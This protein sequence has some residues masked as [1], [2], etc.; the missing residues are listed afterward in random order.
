MGLLSCL[1]IAI[2]LTALVGTSVAAEVT[3]LVPPDVLTDYQ[4]WLAGRDPLTIRAFGGPGARRDVVEVVLAQQALALGGEHGPVRFIV[5]PTYER[6]L[7][8]LMAGNAAM[9]ATSAW[10]SDLAALREVAMSHAVIPEGGFTAGIYVMPTNTRALAAHTLADVRGLAFVSDPAWKAD[11]ATLQQLAP[12]RLESTPTWPAMVRMVAAGNV[13][14]LLAPFQATED[15]ALMAEGVRLVP[16]PNFTVGL[17]GSR[18]FA[19]SL[20]HDDGDRL[21]ATLDR[22]L[23]QLMADGTVTRAYQEAG[24]LNPRVT[25]WQRVP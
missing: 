22:G 2:C 14:A 10:R 15:L 23:E 4:T 1:N 25:Q 18:H 3:L 16:I 17:L 19:V 13:D 8:E 6:I 21:A 11:W 5:A 24:F 9:L 12:S 20:K 7:V